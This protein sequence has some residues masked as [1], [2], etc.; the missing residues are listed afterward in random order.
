M[1]IIPTLL[2]NKRALVKTVGFRHE[3]YLGDPINAIRLFNDY[4]AHELIILDI[5]CNEPDIQFLT[6]LASKSRMPLAYGGGISSLKQAMDVI[7]L[8]FDKIVL[9][10]LLFKDHMEVARIIKALGSQSVIGCV[11]ISRN[12]NGQYLLRQ[13][14]S[15]NIDE[16]LDDLTSAG[17]GEIFLYDTDR[18]GKRTGLEIVDFERLCLKTNVPIIIGGGLA[19]YEELAGIQSEVFDAVAVGSLFVYYGKRNAVLINYDIK[20]YG[21]Y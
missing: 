11:E 8:G 20:K 5:D 13:D 19:S 7:R 9:N 3:E 18:E 6:Q 14:L 1:R 17:V 2:I 21:L 12:N 16:F 15:K 10:T 4:E